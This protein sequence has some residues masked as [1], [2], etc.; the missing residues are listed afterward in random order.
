MLKYLKASFCGFGHF[1]GGSGNGVFV[2]CV[3]IEW[4][5]RNTGIMGGKEECEMPSISTCRCSQK[6]NLEMSVLLLSP[7]LKPAKCIFPIIALHFNLFIFN[8]KIK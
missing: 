8:C 6:L 3:L 5:M 1:E 7:R 4:N 2:Y